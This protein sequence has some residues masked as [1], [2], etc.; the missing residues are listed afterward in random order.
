MSLSPKVR[1]ER[2][3]FAAKLKDRKPK[4]RGRCANCF[5][6]YVDESPNQIKKFCGDQCKKEFHAHGS[7]YGPLK[8]RLEKLVRQGGRELGARVRSLESEVLVLKATSQLPS[9]PNP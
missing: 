8:V 3:A 2:R 9:Q 7:A 6:M 5:K 4:R 1:R